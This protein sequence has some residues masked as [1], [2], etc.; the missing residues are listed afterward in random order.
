MP[1]SVPHPFFALSL[2][3]VLLTAS[4][5]SLPVDAQYSSTYARAPSHDGQTTGGG[6]PTRIIAVPQF[7]VFSNC[8]V[9]VL[10][11]L[12]RCD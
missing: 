11:C 2:G 7:P 5:F 3:S 1:C 10:G 9:V 12:C 6:E 4:L 8:R